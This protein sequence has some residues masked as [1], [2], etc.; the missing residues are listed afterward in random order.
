MRAHRQHLCAVEGMNPP[1][2]DE[3]HMQMMIGQH[4]PT[5]PCTGGR[6]RGV[7]QPAGRMEHTMLKM[8]K[9][10]LLFTLWL[11]LLNVC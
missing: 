4:M 2:F 1:E 3:Q 9:M 8:R 11:D 6:L 7:T 5:K 10:G